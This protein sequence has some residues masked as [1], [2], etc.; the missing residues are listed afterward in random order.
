MLGKVSVLSEE[1]DVV[2]QH[3]LA[4][5]E[6]TIGREGADIEFKDDPFMSPLH[7][8][9]TASDGKFVLR[10]LGSRNGTWVFLTQPHR[11]ADGDLILIGSQV[12]LFR[13]LG[14]PGPQPPESDATRRMGSLVPS[15]DIARLIQVRSDGSQRDTLHLSPGRNLGIGRE[16]GDWIFPYD[17]SM[18]GLHAE[19]R[20]EDADFVIMDTGS[21]NGVAISIRGKLL[22]NPGTRLL[23]G[24]RLLRL[25]TP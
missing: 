3:L 20:S 13:R 15:A 25:E 23:V 7:V 5:I 14:Y 9:V 21:R 16:R 6:T 18:S 17:P 11:L 2:E 4:G 19:V 22:L 1:G 12:L 10:D 8:K 24:D